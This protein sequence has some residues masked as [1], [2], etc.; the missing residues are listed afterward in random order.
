MIS[1]NIRYVFIFV[2][3]VLVQVLVFDK[4]YLSGYFNAFIYVMLILLLPIEINKYFLLF[5]AFI[6]GLSVDI[7][8]ST[9][10]LHAS[11]SVIMAYSRH[12]VLQVY[13]PREGYETNKSPGIKSYGLSWFI[14]YALSLILI[15]HIF[16]F[17]VDAFSF[18]LFFNTLIKSLLSAI[19]S[20]FFV[21][22]GHLLLMKD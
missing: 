12:Y 4:I 6:L 21:I 2:F 15:H 18:Y 16:L 10:G 20:L 14:K 9:P 22:L 1:K 17:F 8:N 13:S 11:A 7:F 19:I 5:I 3:S